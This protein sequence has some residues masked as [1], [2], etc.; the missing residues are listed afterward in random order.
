MSSSTPDAGGLSD[1]GTAFSS[2]SSGV[3]SNSFGFTMPSGTDTA[4][5]GDSFAGLSGL[6][7]GM[8]LPSMS[9]GANSFG[10][11]MPGGG[12]DLSSLSNGLG[13]ASKTL[14]A[15]TTGGNRVGGVGRGGMML[16]AQ[17]FAS[18]IDNELSAGGSTEGNSLIAL[19]QKYRPGATA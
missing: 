11:S 2:G 4:A 10:F 14:S 7:S 1:I 8:S 15:P 5:G 19:L 16:R 13:A 12:M 18:P 17:N 3:G 6:Q 9:G